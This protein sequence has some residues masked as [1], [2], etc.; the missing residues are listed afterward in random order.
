LKCEAGDE[1][2]WKRMRAYNKQ[3]VRLTESLFDEFRPW[4]ALRGTSS[5]KRLRQVLEAA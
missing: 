4:I 3:D 5:Q 2:A 1:S